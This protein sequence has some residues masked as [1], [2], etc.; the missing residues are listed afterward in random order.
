MRG[1]VLIALGVSQAATGFVMNRW[2]EPFCKFKL[3]IIGTAIV[4]LAA[5]VSM[6]CYF[7]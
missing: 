6:L 1:Y 7:L 5:F 4:E 2:F 3:G